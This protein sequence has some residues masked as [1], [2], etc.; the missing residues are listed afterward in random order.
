[1]TTT[2]ICGTPTSAATA[3]CSLRRTTSG[4]SA[5]T[6][7][8]PSASAPTM[9]LPARRGSHPNGSLV[10][11]TAD[12]DGAFE[13]YVARADG[14]VSTRLTFWG[15]LRTQV[16]GWL[17]DDGDPRRQHDRAGRAAAGVRLRGAGRR[18][19]EPATAL[20]LARRHRA[21]ARTAGYCSRPR[22][23]SS[24]P[25]GSATAAA[26]RRS[27]GSTWQARGVQEGVRRPPVEPGEPAVD[28]G[29]GRQASGS[30][31]S[32]TMRS[33]AQ[34]YSATARQAGAEHLAAD[35]AL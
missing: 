19:A 21:R 1:M 5:E 28:R 20:R 23:P 11:W 2:P 33:A 4:S 9:R 14:G 10:A 31:S 32:P 22:Q 7:A 13:V 35:P 6:A 30:V 16:R 34:V 27:C 3:S 17:S 8:A 29:R 18:V 12:R 24:L 25:G 15:Q 26:Q